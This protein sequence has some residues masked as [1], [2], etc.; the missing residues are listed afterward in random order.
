MPSAQPSALLNRVKR[1]ERKVSVDAD[2]LRRAAW[3]R[4]LASD[5]LYADE[6]EA[7]LDGLCSHA[8]EYRLRYTA[9]DGE[10]RVRLI[11][12]FARN[13]AGTFYLKPTSLRP[14]FYDM[15]ASYDDAIRGIRP[16]EQRWSSVYFITGAV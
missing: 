12:W 15:P 7:I 16:M 6:L 11:Q 14:S 4:M 1:L 9:D 2:A 8:G 13:A 10:E 5:P 3:R